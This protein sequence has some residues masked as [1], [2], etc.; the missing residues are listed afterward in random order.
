MQKSEVQS[1]EPYTVSSVCLA[2]L[3]A[4]PVADMRRRTWPGEGE[5]MHAGL[6]TAVV[7][8]PE[9]LFRLSLLV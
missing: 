1:C 5:L 6:L 7:L 2:P 3:P 8:N 4:L 9:Q